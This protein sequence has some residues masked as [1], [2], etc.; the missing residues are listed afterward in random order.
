MEWGI[1]AVSIA[2]ITFIFTNPFAVLDMTCEVISP[3]SQL[4]PITIPALDWR[5]CFLE[6]MLTQGAMVRGDIDLPFTRQ[7]FGT[8]PFLY[9]IE[10]QLRWGMGPLLG[11]LAFAG[12][13]WAIW[14]TVERLE[15][16]DWRTVSQRLPS[17]IPN[18]QSP[19]PI[20][21][22]LSWCIPYFLSTGSFH[23]KFMRYMQ[24]LTP[25][26]VLFG[27]AMLVQ[28]PWN[29]WRWVVGTAVF[30]TTAL[31]AFAFVNQYQQ[32][33]PWNVASDWVYENVPPGTLIVSEQWDDPLPTS[34]LVNG[35]W[36]QRGEFRS[37]ELTWL[38]RVGERDSEEALL[39]NLALL[40]EAEYVA[41]MTNRAYGVVPRLPGKFPI[42]HQY[43]QLLFNGD[44][45][46]EPVFVADRSPNLLGVS[47]VADTFNQPDLMP[48]NAVSAH[49]NAHPHLNLGRA[50]ESFVVYDQPLTIIFQNTGN[51]T[52]EEML[53]LFAIPPSP[54][55]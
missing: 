12:F 42:S 27:A 7:Y 25:F 38:T 31:Y 1:T 50:D 11:L 39:V 40:T 13:G 49:L 2:L 48:P 6:N 36:R 21:L 32:A 52:S 9:F 10:M 55:Q 22:I 41:I 54:P 26:L 34:K 46:Y 37:A 33:H 20:L 29:R 47:L 4:G 19:I 17:L 5:S 24:P 18:P 8:I 15:I 43:H 28:L 30:T 44:L 3:A 35:E 51:L 14:Q 23:V 16:R 45:G 53:K